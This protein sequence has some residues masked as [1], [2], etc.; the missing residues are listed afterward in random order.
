M[1]ARHRT[2]NERAAEGRPGRRVRCFLLMVTNPWE[3]IMSL[4]HNAATGLL[5]V[6]A[7]VD[8]SFAQTLPTAPTLPSIPEIRSLPTVPNEQR[9]GSERE[10]IQDL[11][12]RR[13]IDREERTDSRN[14]GTGNRDSG[15]TGP[16]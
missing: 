7:L 5:A 14:S 10:K 8:P 4:K 6:F 9:Y 12:N 13:L 11:Q 1:Q 3:F 15:T 2:S 16:R